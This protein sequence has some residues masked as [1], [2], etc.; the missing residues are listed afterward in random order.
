M[1]ISINAD[2]GNL[3][4]IDIT[5]NIEYA[6]TP[7]E[8]DQQYK[9]EELNLLKRAVAQKLRTLKDQVAEPLE[10][11]N[12]PYPFGKALGLNC[13]EWLVG[14]AEFVQTLINR[15]GGEKT[16]FLTGAGG[17]GKTSLLQAGLIPV[18]LKYDQLPLFVAAND[19][20]LDFCIKR[21]IIKEIGSTKYLASLP[22]S[23]F[24][25]AVADC[26]PKG[27]IL[28]LLIDRFESFFR[29]IQS[30]K[31]DFKKEWCLSISTQINIRWLFSINQG[32]VPELS[33]FES[34]EVQ[35]ISDRVTLSPLTRESAQEVIQ[36]LAAKANIRLDETVV[37]L[38]LDQLGVLSIDPSE[39]QTVCY[40]LSGGC[41]PIVG[42]WKLRDYESQGM[43]DGILKQALENIIQTFP[44]E[45]RQ[46]AWQILA[47]LTE[48][49]NQLLT[50]SAISKKLN[51][52]GFPTANLPH[53]LERLEINHLIDVEDERYRLANA[54]LWPCVQQWTDQ[55]AARTK[56]WKEATRQIE[57][58]RKTAMRGLVGGALGFALF[59]LLIYT[60]ERPDPIYTILFTLTMAAIGGIAGFLLTLDIDLTM[61]TYRGA[62]T[63]LRYV[64]GGVGGAIALTVGILLYTI[65][66]YPPDKLPEVLPMAALEGGIWGL[67]VGSGAAWVVMNTSRGV[68]LKVL[69][70]SALCGLILLGI[71]SFGGKLIPDE[72]KAPS[73]WLI[74]LAGALTPLFFLA[75][76]MFG[77]PLS[78]DGGVG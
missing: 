72:W 6:P 9:I 48:E 15:L 67:A 47:C 51:L 30:Q 52:Y 22:L 33:F 69:V 71:E 31:D 50:P 34:E 1:G 49:T 63:W 14:R 29:H 17:V 70:V 10:V 27:K 41:G 58:I 75:A 78:K 25:Q 43:A 16:I 7:S 40:F 68:W 44:L 38:I 56:A 4:D 42:E 24:L 19:D 60:G 76:A 3:K 26:L 45:E 21:Q 37:G 54:C 28:I 20:P 73:W 64:M 11:I 5:Q 39:L 57:Q 53:L 46:T 8:I 35:P 55:Q 18:L 62:R 2:Y 65:Y 74:F 61:A 59:D 32:F 36:L 23:A 77:R 66:N 12:N 13:G